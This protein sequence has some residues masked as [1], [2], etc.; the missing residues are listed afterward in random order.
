MK[1]DNKI[2][3]DTALSPEEKE[4]LLQQF[5]EKDKKETRLGG[6]FV[7]F[8]AVAL[9]VNAVVTSAMYPFYLQDLILRAFSEQS[10]ITGAF[11][12][13]AAFMVG[14]VLFAVIVLKLSMSISTLVCA[15]RK[16]GI[17]AAAGVSAC[18]IGFIDLLVVVLQ[19]SDQYTYHETFTVI[20]M[21]VNIICLILICCC[22]Y[23]SVFT[24]KI[25]KYTYSKV[26]K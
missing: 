18:L 8:C 22:I 26:K 11:D 3:N 15:I 13:N 16:K 12:N 23:M 1:N 4:Q 10:E 5:Y 17:R 25:S 6:I 24:D 14:L 20:A 21:A 2:I 19:L 7:V 9:L